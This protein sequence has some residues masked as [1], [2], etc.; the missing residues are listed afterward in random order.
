[1]PTVSKPFSQRKVLCTLLKELTDAQWEAET[2]CAGW[3]AAEIAA[4]L[5]VRERSLVA[6]L[7]IVVPLFAGFHE[8]GVAKTAIYPRAWLIN[9]LADGPPWW[10]RIG[11]VHLGEDWIHTQDI[12]RGQAATADPTH[13][14]DIDSGTHHPELAQAL[15]RA[16]D[17]FAP[18]SLRK[19]PGPFRVLLTNGQGYNRTWL[20]RPGPHFALR[21]NTAKVAPDVTLTGE[22]GELLLACTGRDRVAHVTYTGDPELITTLR[23]GLIGI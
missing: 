14:L 5:I 22:I 7:G 1:M 6:A 3:T 18:L 11:Q 17:R 16:C 15:A 19:I 12:L 13:E 21:A 4:H 8:R 10:A 23:N 9:R 20:V 2:V